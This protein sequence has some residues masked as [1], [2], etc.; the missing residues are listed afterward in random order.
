MKTLIVCASRYGATMEIGRWI[1]DRLPWK[2]TEVVSVTEDPDPSGF[3]LVFLGGGVYNEKVGKPIVQ[4]AQKRLEAL[5]GK[6]LAAFAVCL[7]TKGVYMKGRFFGG[8]LYLQ[9]L[10]DA[11]CDHP[12]LYAGVLS[13][14]IIPK[15]LTEKDYNLLMHFYTRI[16]KRDITEVPYRTLMDKRQVWDFTEKVL[17]RLEGHF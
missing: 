3:E 4:Y 11:L 12:P 9:P 1:A 13:G 16:L 10:L 6:Y 15:K 14:E 2:E 5:A 8:W 17:H 7:D